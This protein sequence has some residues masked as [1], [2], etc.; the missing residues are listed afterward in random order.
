MQYRL[1]SYFILELY[2]P[3]IHWRE[4]NENVVVFEISFYLWDASWMRELVL[5]LA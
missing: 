1:I 2:I 4:S 5:T 3:Y